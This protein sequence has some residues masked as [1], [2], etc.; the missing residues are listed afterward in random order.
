MSGAR[1]QYPH[2][3]RGLDHAWFGH[4]RSLDRKPLTWPGR[5]PVALWITVPLELFPLDAPAQPFRPLG[6]LDRG[7]PDYWSYSNR[8]YGLRIGIYRIMRV[9][10]QLELT[11][12]AA[13]NAAVAARHPRIVDE[14]VNRNWEIM[15][16]GIDMGQLHHGGL[17]LEDERDRVRKAR[18]TLI[19]ATG[20][21]IR[22]WYSPGHS[23]SMHTLQL[24]KECG[25]DYVADWANDDLPYLQQTSAGTLCAL[26]LTTEWSDRA[27]LVQHNLAVEDYEAQVMRAFARLAAEARSSGGGRIL[28]LCVSPWIMGYPHRIATL[29]RLLDRILET[30]AVWHANGMAIADTF[31]MQTT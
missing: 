7:Y 26:P 31:M 10:D 24:V 16:S 13:V 2:R 25:F 3:R 17:S 20:K 19:K 21:P 27:L 8:D 22:G 29:Q 1:L 5:K 11:A 12:T 28:S 15:A 18:D 30:G 6:A 14:A 9:L 23:E 4:E